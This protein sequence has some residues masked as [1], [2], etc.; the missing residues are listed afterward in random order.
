LTVAE[1]ESWLEWRELPSGTLAPKTANFVNDIIFHPCAR[2][3]YVYVETFAPAFLN[4]LL[5]VSFFDLEDALRAH[6][7]F[8]SGKAG[9]GGHGRKLHKMKFTRSGRETKTQRYAAKA[10]RTLLII[11]SPLEAIGFAWLLYAATDEFFYDWQTLLN[12]STF[13]SQPIFSGPLQRRRGPGNIPI[14]PGGQPT[15][16]PIAVQDRGA[17]ATSNIS[18]DLPQGQF[19]AIFALTVRG[20]NNRIEGVH[21]RFRVTGIFGTFLLDDDPISIERKEWVDLLF[22]ADFFLFGGAG[23]AIV[24]ELVGQAVPIGLESEKGRIM[25]VR[26]G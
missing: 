4:L 9:R 21:L 2:P 17:W 19:T 12:A 25:V 24:W 22:K 7:T 13:C 11:T 15:R 18:A 20:P 5:M 6:A 23:G 26:T 16:M 10:L 3:W 8:I 1:E 14:L